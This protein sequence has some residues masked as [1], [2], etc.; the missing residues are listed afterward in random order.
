MYG[1]FQH[2]FQ[3][4]FGIY[5]LARECSK[6]QITSKKVSQWSLQVL[7]PP[8]KFLII[9]DLSEI[10]LQQKSL[11]QI[12]EDRVQKTP[13]L[14]QDCA[15]PEVDPQKDYRP[16]ASTQIAENINDNSSQS[17]TPIHQVEPLLDTTTLENYQLQ[18]A[19]QPQDI[20]E[21]LGTT[22]FEGYVRTPL[23]TLDGLY[24]H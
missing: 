16:L 7:P 1:I 14:I 11:L 8:D 18:S 3:V 21:I 9:P 19:T 15:S 22:A 6:L 4:F 5:C 23:E 2:T 13:V 10:T 12:T 24:I 17:D 20:S